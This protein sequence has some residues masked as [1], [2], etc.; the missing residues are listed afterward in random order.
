M[1]SARHS[2]AQRVERAST[3]VV[4]LDAILG[5]GL[6]TNHLYLIDGEP[7]TG[8]TTL[9]LQ[10]LLEGVRI[11]E[12]GLYVTLSESKVELE[13]VAHSHGWHLDGIEIFELSAAVA[14]PEG[15]YTLFHPAEVELQE[16]VGEVL[17]AVE[18]AA[19][20]RVVF[21]SLSEMRLLARDPLRF[22]R[23]I[24][25]LKQFFGG[26]QCTVLLLDDKSAPEGDMQLHSLAHG[27]LVLQHLAMEYGAERRR[28]HVTKLRGSRFWGG[29][30]DFRICTGGIAVYPRIRRGA[31]QV[32]PGT[33]SLRSNSQALDELLGGGLARGTSTL[34]T[35][36]AGTGKTVLSVQYVCAAVERGERARLF[37]FDER[38]STF[39]LRAEGLG[40][41]LSA[42]IADG[43]LSIVQIEP[44]EMSPGEFANEVMRAVQVDDVSL[45]VIDSINGFMNSMPSERL[46]GV[47]LH[48]MLSFLADHGVTSVLT[49]V[50]QG[51][52]GGPVE[53]AVD[54]SYLA[55]TVV[56]L[57][58]FEY[59]G[60]VRK[61]I[62]VVKKRSGAHEHTIRE[63]RVA[64]GGLQVGQPLTD[65]RGVL[66]GVP[67]Y[68]GQ[69]EPL[70]DDGLTS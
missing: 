38:A 49:L 43:R 58:Y 32:Q 30:H 3:G 46:L 11:G 25:A 16:T 57:R 5:G 62:S 19:P 64:H 37:M 15:D 54:V 60:A 1:K 2:R 34:I 13:G 9:A 52:F 45:I 22:R 51:V 63:C 23:Q 20:A 56:L 41:D 24:L 31:V 47:Q 26:R 18:K 4:G 59:Q 28:L 44:A 29:Y 14:S 61:A 21:D 7:G 55:D 70:M 10:F 36:A 66:T 42:A 53:D 33:E 6:P 12:S 27:V 39:H 17:K 8:K 69:G 40:M 48:E 50:Q 67:Q 68:T 65:F 35:G